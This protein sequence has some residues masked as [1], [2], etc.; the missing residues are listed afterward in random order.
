[1][2]HDSM[3]YLHYDTEFLIRHG[4][5]PSILIPSFLLFSISLL[6]M[7]KGLLSAFKN[8]SHQVCFIVYIF[9]IL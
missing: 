1:M 8:D 6:M 3:V 5:V 2:K 7:T 9:P 4:D